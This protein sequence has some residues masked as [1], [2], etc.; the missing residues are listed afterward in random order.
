MSTMP[1]LLTR[2]TRA[3]MLRCAPGPT[4]T[5]SQ[6]SAT[7]CR[8][9]K[10]PAGSLSWRTPCP[11]RST[12]H[13]PVAPPAGHERD[14][15]ACEDEHMSQCGATT[16]SGTSREDC[17]VTCCSTAPAECQYLALPAAQAEKRR[18]LSASSIAGRCPW[19]MVSPTSTAMARDHSDGV[20]GMVDWVVSCAAIAC[21]QRR[22][23]CTN[24]SSA[25]PSQH[26]KQRLQC[27]FSWIVAHTVQSHS[28]TGHPTSD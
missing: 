5:I 24:G 10:R 25:E 28:Q 2:H 18:L 12:C 19:P 13:S 11:P 20:R 26:A 27:H 4:P 3:S 6:S 14:W 22:I 23:A 8:A 9:G 15:A 7:T 21:W 17:E 1:K 16:C